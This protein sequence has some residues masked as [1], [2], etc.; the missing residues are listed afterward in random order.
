[1]R[2][3][4]ST[5]YRD[6]GTWEVKNDQF[7][8]LWDNWWGH[9]E[10]CWRVYREGE[11]YVSWYI[12]Q[13]GGIERA[14]VVAEDSLLLPEHFPAE[15]INNNGSASPDLFDGF[16]L[17]DAQKSL[18]KKLITRALEETGGNRT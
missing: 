8:G 4:R 11:G 16:S 5:N 13:T 7:C 3:V 14:R 6:E 18:E 15:I 2:A 12:A 10:R 9:V 17:K 1:M